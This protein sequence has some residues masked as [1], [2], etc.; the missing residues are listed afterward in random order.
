MDAALYRLER[1]VVTVALSAMVLLVFADAA[2]R[3][4]AAF[5]ELPGRAWH[6]KELAMLLLVWTGLVGASMATHRGRH[7]S[8]VP[9]GARGRGADVISRAVIVAFCV[10]MVGLGVVYL[11]G[12]A[13]IPG[14]VTLGG[15]LPDTGLPEWSMVVVIPYAFGVIGLRAALGGGR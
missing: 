11:F 3:R 8:L 13:G 14:L 12:G 2:Q 1:A 6:S 5:V 10:V 7:V 15:R 9:R 4:L